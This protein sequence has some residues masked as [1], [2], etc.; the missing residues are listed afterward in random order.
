VTGPA[1]D[2]ERHLRARPEP[3]GPVAPAINQ[4]TAG[5][6]HADGTIP[7]ALDA[8]DPLGR[9]LWFK[10]FGRGGEALEQNGELVFRPYGRKPW[11]LTVFAINEN[12]GSSAKAL[13]A[14]ER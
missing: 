4:L 8:S 11:E 2:L 7:V 5:A 10:V 6:P 12:G 1:E 3:G 14:P 9:P 13:S